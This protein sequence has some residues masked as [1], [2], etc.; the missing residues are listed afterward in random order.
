MSKCNPTPVLFLN[1]DDANASNKE[2]WKREC[3]Y[4][5]LPMA[6]PG[7]AVVT[8]LSPETIVYCK[9]TSTGES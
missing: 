5:E 4:V 7:G 1:L 9:S 2:N 3:N 6:A 8:E